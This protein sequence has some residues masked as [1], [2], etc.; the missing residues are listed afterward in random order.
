MSNNVKG[1]LEFLLQAQYCIDCTCIVCCSAV[2]GSG[3]QRYEMALGKAFKAIHDTL[4]CSNDHL[5]V[6]DLHDKPQVSINGT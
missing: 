5:Q 3:E 6:V 1:L 4:M 2:V